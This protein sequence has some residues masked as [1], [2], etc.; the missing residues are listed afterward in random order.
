MSEAAHAAAPAGV[1]ENAEDRTEAERFVVGVGADDEH[2]RKGGQG[3]VH[4]LAGLSMTRT[5]KAPQAGVVLPMASSA[6]PST[7][8]PGKAPGA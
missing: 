5:W 1:G 2:A 4:Q 7:A 6:G 8:R 3:G